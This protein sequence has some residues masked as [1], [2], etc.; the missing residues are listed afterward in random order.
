MGERNAGNSTNGNP[1]GNGGNADATGK[2]APKS[3]GGENGPGPDAGPVAST[4]TPAGPGSDA[5]PVA[6]APAKSGKANHATVNPV[7]LAPDDF[8]RDDTGAIVYKSDGVTPRRKRGRKAGA[9]ITA[10]ATAP[11]SS[12]AKTDAARAVV[13]TEMLAAQFQIL[14]LGIATLTKFE[15][16]KLDDSEAMEMAKATANVMAQFDYVPDP[17]VAAVLGLVTTTSM[18][19]GPR[20]YLFNKDRAQKKAARREAGIVAADDRA[21]TSS[22][23]PDG[24][25]NMGQFSG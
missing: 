13:A 11:K 3:Q 25:L 18:I 23:F 17:K 2:G 22:A 14:N 10:K 7:S 24:P 19:Y 8:E 6:S 1:G 4:G 15:D 12:P 9:S 16:F 5:G 21:A 20:V